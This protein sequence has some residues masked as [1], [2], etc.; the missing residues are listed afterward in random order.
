MLFEIVKSGKPEDDLDPTFFGEILGVAGRVGVNFLEDF[1]RGGIAFQDASQ[2]IDV[3]DWQGFVR[4]D[5]I[6]ISP[7]AAP[8]QE[9]FILTDTRITEM[10]LA[11]DQLMNVAI[12]YKANGMT[13][14]HWFDTISN[15]MI[16]TEY[17][18]AESPFV[19]HDD[20]RNLQV[21]LGRSDVIFLY[22]LDGWL[23]KRIQRDRYGVEYDLLDLDG[24]ANRIIDAGLNKNLRLKID[25]GL[26]IR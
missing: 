15:M 17:P 9:T 21:N 14:L 10:T 18:G 4:E 8:E 16:T 7:L 24:Q 13:K 3:Q 19:V 20:V 5:G 6:Y 23:R 12:A 11:F 25:L 2:G 26:Q 1:A 22:I